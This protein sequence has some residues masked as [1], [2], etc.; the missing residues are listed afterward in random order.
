M[1]RF[2]LAVYNYLKRRRWLCALIFIAISTGLLLLVLRLH[3]KEDI[4]DFLPL[5]ND[6]QNALKVYQDI[7]GANKIFAI[8]QCQDS[9][10]SNP[11]IFVEAIEQFTSEVEESTPT[12]DKL[13]VTSRIDIEKMSEMADFVY[14]N[15]PLFLTE[16]DYERIDSLLTSSDYI[17]R[18]LMEDKQMLMF[19]AGSLLSDNIQRDPL[20]IFT[21]VV[22][23]LQQSSGTLK[24]EMYDGYIF[25]PDMQRAIVMIDSPY[26]ASETEQNAKLVQ[27]LEECADK[28]SSKVGDVQINLTG[29][30]VIAVENSTQIKRDSMLS[31]AIAVGIILLILLV[32]FRNI[33]NLALIVLSIGWGWLFGLGG[34]AMIHD[35]VSIIVIGISSVILGIAVNYPLHLLAHLYHTTTVRSTLREIVA[36]LVVGNITTVGAFLS[37]VPLDSVALKDLG[38]FSSF[39][40]IGTLVF[41]LLF[42]PHLSAPH[43]PV[44]IPLLNKAS[45][46]SI[47][48]KPLIIW[49]VIALTLVFGYFSTKTSFDSNMSHINFMSGQQKADMEYFQKNMTKASDNQ[50]VYVVSSGRTMNEALDKGLKTNKALEHLQ[51]A[52][53]VNGISSCSRFLVSEEE[54]AKRI[55]L[56]NAFVAKH[57]NTIKESTLRSA[58]EEG[59]AD[60]SFADF[61]SI[62]DAD[63]APKEF[64]YFEDIAKGMFSSNLSVD[65]AANHYEVVDVLTV[66]PEKV[67]SVKDYLTDNHIGDYSF[68]VAGM[69]SAIANAL[70]DNFNYIGWACGLIVFFF[71][72]FSFGSL[73]LALLSF[74]P[75]AVSWIWIL[76]IMG[77]LGIQFNIVNVILATFIFGQGD[78]YTIFMTEGSCYEYAYRR[79]MLS[80]YK[81]SITISALIMFVGI[82]ALIVAKH[83]ALR[84]LAEVTIVGMFSVV[85]MAYIFPPLIFNVLVKRKGEFR[86]RPLSIKPLLSMAWSAAVV[87]V[88]LLIVH[89]VGFALFELSKPTKKRKFFFH[90]FVRRLCLFFF[91]TVP[92]IKF[93]L[94]NQN[95]EN[96]ESP[97]IVTSNHQSALDV[98]LLMAVSPKLILAANE[99]TSSGW[100]TK[101]IFRWMDFCTLSGD[102]DKDMT[103]LKSRISEGYSIAVFPE[104]ERNPDSTILKFNDGACHLAQVLSLNIVPVIIH[105]VNYCLPRNGLQLHRGTVTVQVNSRIPAVDRERS[106]QENTRWLHEYYVENYQ[107]L[108]KEIE[109]C[110]YYSDFVVDRY[111]YK[112]VEIT[113]SVKSRLSKAQNCHEWIDQ[114]SQSSEVGIID[115]NF[116]ELALLFA[117]VHPE[118]EVFLAIQDEAN[119]EVARY[120]AHGVVN[121]I[122]FAASLS[123]L[124][125]VDEKFIYA[126]DVDGF[127]VSD[128][129]RIKP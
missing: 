14:Q 6:N 10:R 74:L 42:L 33:K 70:S 53:E 98:V 89:L 110:S 73:E 76:G 41:V 64:S 27:M 113:K 31:V 13:Q 43:K 58:H 50:S 51:E 99:H 78:D 83:P 46:F 48:K 65:C 35:S 122:H 66:S 23:R 87:S 5:G 105:G 120:S 7:S 85:L 34:L 36:P 2:V 72:W 44:D 118:V 63:Y 52:N 94:R 19:P 32:V 39:L 88:L 37:L 45:N 82:G 103:L 56:W 47:E 77:V 95:K 1:T 57:G 97:V 25:S 92:G 104:E 129:H 9:A 68:D 69:N 79:K 109:T 115:D 49:S 59:F 91:R 40:L 123:E 101:S 54:Q 93:N 108:S 126:T 22:G 121:N 107:I 20:N 16:G 26:G 112:G 15:I 119:S 38:L 18:Q 81:S 90:K 100:M 80:S 60:D 96:F 55:G 62:L 30:P 11:D 8:F 106:C 75:M 117:L 127:V 12:D 86:M 125:S 102:T 4:S 61:F 17:P 29:G 124:A 24:Y 67:S 114:F 116:G 71:L 21:P 28:T 3:Y 84:S 128:H 111:R